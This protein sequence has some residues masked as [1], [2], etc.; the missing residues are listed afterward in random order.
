VLAPPPSSLTPVVVR[1]GAGVVV[2]VVA[3]G[4]TAACVTVSAGAGVDDD[5][6]GRV[7]TRSVRACVQSWYCELVTWWVVSIIRTCEYLQQN[8]N[9]IDG[10]VPPSC[11]SGECGRIFK[12]SSVWA[13]GYTYQVAGAGECVV[14]IIS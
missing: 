11:R 8:E 13:C 3:S 1:A 6:S 4:H 12:C 9:K 5:D 14:I 10:Y 2:V 7:A